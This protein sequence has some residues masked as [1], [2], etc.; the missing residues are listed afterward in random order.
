MSGTHSGRVMMKPQDTWIGTLR[1]CPEW[2]AFFHLYWFGFISI[3]QCACLL[4]CPQPKCPTLTILESPGRGSA[5]Q[6]PTSGC[7]RLVGI[8]TLGV[9][10]WILCD[11]F[12]QPLEAASKFR[13]NIPSSLLHKGILLQMSQEAKLTY[14]KQFLHTLIILNYKKIECYKQKCTQNTLQN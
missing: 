13:F 2:F 5:A 8:P 12:Q 4:P 9:S 10:T 1:A 3:C 14:I 7:V 6:I 11:W